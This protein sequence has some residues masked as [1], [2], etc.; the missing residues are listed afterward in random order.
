MLAFIR[1]H[2]GSWLMPAAFAGSC[3]TCWLTPA[4]RA[5]DLQPGSLLAD[6][7]YAD[8]LK[9]CGIKIDVVSDELL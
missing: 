5:D 8:R 6:T 7:Q 3:C 4:T 9:A 1:F 2:D